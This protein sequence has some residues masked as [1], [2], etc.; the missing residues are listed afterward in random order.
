M[1]HWRPLRG[2]FICA[3]LKP[4]AILMVEFDNAEEKFIYT[5]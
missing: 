3:S 5:R 1:F 2:Q 4:T